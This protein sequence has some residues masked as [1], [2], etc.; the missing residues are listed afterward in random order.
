MRT[1]CVVCRRAC[2]SLLTTLE[3]QI[4]F[5]W[6]Q[7]I[8]QYQNLANECP[9]EKKSRLIVETFL[10]YW[11]SV[12]YIFMLTKVIMKSPQPLENSSG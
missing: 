2:G 3:T 7:V 1:G 10:R 4:L 8:V 5:I 6:T 11:P 12:Y 9:S